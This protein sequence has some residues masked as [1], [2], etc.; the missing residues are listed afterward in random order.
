MMEPPV[1]NSPPNTLTPSRWAFESRPFLELP[2]PFLCA[3]NHLREN[4]ADPHLG[5]VLPVADGALVLL[6]A[7]EFED[8]DFVAA[9]MAGDSALDFRLGERVSADHFAAVANHCQD[10]V[11][12]HLGA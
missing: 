1:T 4:F 7:L 2:R 12:F 8:D 9:A 10:A 3:I 5:I 6:F 11:E